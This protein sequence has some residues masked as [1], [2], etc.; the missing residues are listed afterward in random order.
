MTMNASCE[1]IGHGG[2]SALARA[3]TLAAFDAAREVG[4]DWIEFD[5]RA[6]R[7]DL[8]LDGS[9]DGWTSFSVILPAMPPPT[10]A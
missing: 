1:R 7:G 2:A 10:Q 3:N 6:H 8:V 9:R 5:V 4:V